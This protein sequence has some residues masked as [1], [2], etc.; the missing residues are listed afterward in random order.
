MQVAR[1]NDYLPVFFFFFGWSWLS[2]TCVVEAA[3]SGPAEIKFA[4]EGKAE[5]GGRTDNYCRPI[6]GRLVAASVMWLDFYEKSAIFRHCTGR[7]AFLGFCR[8]LLAAL[9][10]EFFLSPL[11]YATSFYRFDPFYLHLYSS[12]SRSR[13]P[14]LKTHH[15]VHIDRCSN[16]E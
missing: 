11:H 15:S 1:T 16:A 3:I 9:L 4:V 12:F 10:P 14:E 7:F 2:L 6:K 8:L 13:D 5:K